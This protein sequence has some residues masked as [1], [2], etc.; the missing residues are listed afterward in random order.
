[1]SANGLELRNL[2]PDELMSEAHPRRTSGIESGRESGRQAARSGRLLVLELLVVALLATALITT[3]PAQISGSLAA[4]VTGGTEYA[5]I[6]AQ[7]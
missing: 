1:M 4:E 7:R 3:D 5:R 2:R 6:L